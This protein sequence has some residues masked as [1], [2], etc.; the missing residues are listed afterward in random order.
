MTAWRVI[1]LALVWCVTLAATNGNEPPLYRVGDVVRARCDGGD[2]LKRLSVY[3]SPRAVWDTYDSSVAMPNAVRMIRA[4]THLRVESFVRHQLYTPV[5]HALY[6]HLQILE[7]T[8]IVGASWHGYLDSLE[9][10]P[11]TGPKGFANICE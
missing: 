3:G 2:E 4:G 11:G 1:A 6:I 8:P 9:V 7:V 10:D 5:S